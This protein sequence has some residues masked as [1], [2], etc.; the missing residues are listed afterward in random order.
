MTGSGVS[1]PKTQP[2]P[3]GILILLASANS[4]PQSL[5]RLLSARQSRH[6][7]SRRSVQSYLDFLLLPATFKLPT[8]ASEEPL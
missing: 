7:N 2:A 8:D 4:H 3:S 6:L 1:G 5:D